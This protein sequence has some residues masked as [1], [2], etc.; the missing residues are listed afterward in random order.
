MAGGSRQG[1]AV[2]STDTGTHG[3]DMM[4][5]ADWAENAPEKVVDWAYRSL[6][7][8]V[9]L[10]KQLVHNHYGKDAKYSYYSG[11]STGGRQGL[12]EAQMFPDDFDGIIAGAPACSYSPFLPCRE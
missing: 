10:A 6:H 11:C 12:K 5:G 8:S 9:V 2:V 3:G 7:G 4:G 1:F